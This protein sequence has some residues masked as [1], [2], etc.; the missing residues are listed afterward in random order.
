MNSPPTTERARKAH[1]RPLNQAG[2]TEEKF[3][4]L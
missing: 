3:T 2:L 1:I 4:L